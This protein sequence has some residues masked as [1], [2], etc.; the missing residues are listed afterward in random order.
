ME[1]LIGDLTAVPQ[2]IEVKLFSDD[3]A[4]LSSAA[5]AVAAAIGRIPGVVDVKDG[6]V[7]AGDAL[8]IAV[9]PAKAALEGMDPDAVT[10]AVE[11]LLSGA[12]A[13][14][15]VESGPKLI[16]IRAWIPGRSRRTTEDV[17]ALRLRAPDGH[18][19]P[20]ERVATLTTVTGQ[21]QIDRDDLKRMLAVTARISGR[22]LGSTI[23]DVQAVLNRPGL[24]P[25][26][27]YSVLGGT[28][29]EQQKAF[30]GLIAVFAA[31]VALVFLLLLFLY[32]RFRTATAMLATTLLALSAV[33]IGL[34]LTHTELNISSMMGMTMIVGIAT[35]VAIFYVS[36]L[37]SLPD[38]LE[39]HEALVQAG[40]NRMRPIAMTTFAAILALL[41]L[42]LGIGAGSAMQQPLAIAIISGLMLQMPLVLVVLPVLLSLRPARG[43][44]ASG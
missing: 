13:T 24:V 19:F 27:V 30:T 26:G 42:A 10:G 28:Y 6:I 9:D 18:F 39:P 33:T 29:A 40:I 25:R 5:P 3:S 16:G 8:T 21:P 22:D 2:P 12:T 14:T 4:L 44:P 15:K 43:K 1:D 41:P 7:P 35:E 36:E 17:A 23:H 34:W 20:L 38:T 31:A 32:E 37:V 11:A